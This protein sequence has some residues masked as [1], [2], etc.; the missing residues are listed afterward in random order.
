[1]ASVTRRLRK[2]LR[3]RTPNPAKALVDDEGFRLAARLE[4]AARAADAEPYEFLQY[5]YR[6]RRGYDPHH[7]GKS[8]LMDL[9]DQIADFELR[10]KEATSGAPS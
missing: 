6:M 9:V 2:H 8:A 7:D 1:M 5:L 4:R 3:W 10:K